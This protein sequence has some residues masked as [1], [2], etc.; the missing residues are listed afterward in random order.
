M[1]NSQKYHLNAALYVESPRSDAVH[2]F[3]CLNFQSFAVPR[4]QAT[5]GQHEISNNTNGTYMCIAAIT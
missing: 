2:M 3:V 4:S 5:S 1:N